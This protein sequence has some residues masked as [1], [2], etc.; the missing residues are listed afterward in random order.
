MLDI[1]HLIESCYNLKSLC[2]FCLFSLNIQRD[3]LCLIM[4]LSSG[5]YLSF[6]GQRTCDVKNAVH[7]G[8]TVST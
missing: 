3:A 7:F 6:W 5:G 1:D 8:K 2:T 4:T